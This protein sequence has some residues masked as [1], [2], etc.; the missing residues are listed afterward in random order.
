MN[1]AD[2]ILFYT[3]KFEEEFSYDDFLKTLLKLDD[4]SKK[5]LLENGLECGFHK[6]C[7]ELAHRQVELLNKE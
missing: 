3:V 6:F 1:K 7:L 5:L 4:E 2:L